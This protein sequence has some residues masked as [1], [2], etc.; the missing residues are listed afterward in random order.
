MKIGAIRTRSRHT[1]TIS[2]A[3]R[4]ASSLRWEEELSISDL[5]VYLSGDSFLIV[6]ADNAL[7]VETGIKFQFFSSSRQKYERGAM[8]ILQRGVGSGE[9]EVGSGECGVGGGEW[10]VGRGEKGVGGERWESRGL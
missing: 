6:Y 7:D 5:L 2:A 1:L 4:L 3:R 9:W 10:G 8:N